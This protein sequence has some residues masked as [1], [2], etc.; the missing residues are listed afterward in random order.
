MSGRVPS[1]GLD[2]D[3]VESQ[4]EAAE[5][6]LEVLLVCIVERACITA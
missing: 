5:S 4:L 1:P 3:T 2:V 6:N